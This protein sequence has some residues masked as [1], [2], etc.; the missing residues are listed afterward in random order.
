M[1]PHK[2]VVRRNAF[3]AFPSAQNGGELEGG[4]ESGRLK[5]QFSQVEGDLDLQEI[6]K[7]V[8]FQKKSSKE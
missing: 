1:D 5:R 6:L 8:P 2:V 4:V 3:L 7:L